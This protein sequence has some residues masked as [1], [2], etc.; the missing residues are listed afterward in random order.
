MLGEGNAM[1]HF[2]I[3]VLSLLLSASIG[4]CAGLSVAPGGLLIEKVPL[5]SL[6]DIEKFTGIKLSIVNNDSFQNT[7]N[8]RAVKPS[9]IGIKW[10]KGYTEIPVPQCF[11]FEK[12][13]VT[14]KGKSTETIKMYLKIPYSEKYYNQKWALGISVESVPQ[15]GSGFGISLAVYPCFYIE[16][17]DKQGIKTTSYGDIGTEPGTIIIKQVTPGKQKNVAKLKIHN[18]QNKTLSFKVYPVIPPPQAEKVQILN[19]PGYQWMPAPD[20]IIPSTQKIKIKANKSKEI[21][22]SLN[23]PA[24]NV[25][26]NKKYQ[27]ILFI[28][29]TDGKQSAFVRV[30]VEI[31]E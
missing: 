1:K 9:D 29:T 27:G 6:Y 26:L 23:I 21:S 17:E 7:Y 28:E 31:K 25:Y 18:N 8:I 13:E 2:T 12:N 24:D 16:T 10:L 22:L 19:S 15:K 5:D 11:T 30:N 3:S 14:V 20:W 4:F